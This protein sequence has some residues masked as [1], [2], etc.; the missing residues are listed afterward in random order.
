MDYK[1]L[2]YQELALRKEIEADY[3]KMIDRVNRQSRTISVWGWTDTP[4]ALKDT[5][6]AAYCAS[7]ANKYAVLICDDVN[8]KKLQ[9]VYIDKL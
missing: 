1:K 4:E 3:D 6:I 8:G 2:Y 9:L 7:K 5:A